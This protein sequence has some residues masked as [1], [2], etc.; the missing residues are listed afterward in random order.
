[1]QLAIPPAITL[2]AL[3]IQSFYPATSSKSAP[4]VVAMVASP[5]SILQC[6]HFAKIQGHC[7]A[8]Y[9]SILV[10]HPNSPTFDTTRPNISSS[11]DD[12]ITSPSR[13][14]NDAKKLKLKNRNRK[15]RTDSCVSYARSG[16][17]CTRHGG[18][19]KCKVDGCGTASQTGGFCRLH[20]GGSRCRIAHCDQFAR[21]RGLC[22]HHNRV[23]PDD[24]KSTTSSHDDQ[25]HV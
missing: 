9:R 3:R 25:N 17:Y 5:C 11:Y 8:H 12:A 10:Q 1:M 15:C 24:N 14:S 19:R 2:P 23:T 16:G 6:N 7:L 4:P 20:G 18:G 22:L 21:I 13:T